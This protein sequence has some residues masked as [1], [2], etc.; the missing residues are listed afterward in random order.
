A[1]V[2]V[3]TFGGRHLIDSRWRDVGP[4]STTRT[5]CSVRCKDVNS[6]TADTDRRTRLLAGAEAT[7]RDL[8]EILA[9]LGARFAEAGHEL[10]LVG[11]S[12]RDAVLGRL[13]TDLDFTTDARPEVVQE[14]LRGFVDHQWDTGIDF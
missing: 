6:P 10:Y 8:S 4:G 12:V 14:L 11:G 3:G 9:P 13:G 2:T 1:A 5:R 7:L